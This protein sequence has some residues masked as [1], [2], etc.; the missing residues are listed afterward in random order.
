MDLS[1]FGFFSKHL[2]DTESCL[3]SLSLVGPPCVCLCLWY[4]NA[5]GLIWKNKKGLMELGNEWCLLKGVGKV[6][7]GG[8]M[9]RVALES[10]VFMSLLG[11]YSPQTGLKGGEEQYRV[12]LNA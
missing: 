8:W 1:L 2:T 12:T 10:V 3:E 7:S 5:F 6:G 9:P 11:K 4:Q